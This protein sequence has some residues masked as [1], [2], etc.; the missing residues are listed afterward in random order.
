MILRSAR[1][2][3]AALGV[4]LDRAFGERGL[5]PHPVALFG[6]VMLAMER[7]IYRDTRAAGMLHAAAGVALATAIGTAAPPTLATY[8]TVSGRML[9][10]T[11][12]A[13][14]GALTVG[15]METARAL[16]PSLVGRDASDLD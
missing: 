10:D 13:V 4:L 1:P 9:G 3:G 12:L 2:G 15:D 5:S 6:R 14:A 8:V 16:L 7:S 11:A